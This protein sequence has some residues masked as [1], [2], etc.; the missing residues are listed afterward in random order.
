MKCQHTLTNYSKFVG[1]EKNSFKGIIAG[2]LFSCCNHGHPFYPIFF[3]ST[4]K[5]IG[6]LLTKL[7]N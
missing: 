7:I 5:I 3:L 6:D 4:A 2:F 1:Q